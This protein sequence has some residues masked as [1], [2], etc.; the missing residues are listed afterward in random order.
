M[1]AQD[2]QEIA[3]KSCI[4]ADETYKKLEVADKNA[5]QYTLLML[6][7]EREADKMVKK[8]N[9]DEQKKLLDL[10]QTDYSSILAEMNNC[11]KNLTGGKLNDNQKKEL[12]ETLS[13]ETGSCKLAY[14]IFKK[15]WKK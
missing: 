8:L 4:C 1:N 15:A 14:L 11:L 5:P 10:I 2:I 3:Q 6:E 12:L 7:N 13:K 9:K